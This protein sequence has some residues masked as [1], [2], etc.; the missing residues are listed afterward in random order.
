MLTCKFPAFAGWQAGSAG[1][2]VRLAA[3]MPLLI[4]L[5]SAVISLLIL[6]IIRPKSE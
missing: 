6:A 1:V 5:F 3:G 4:S 2:R